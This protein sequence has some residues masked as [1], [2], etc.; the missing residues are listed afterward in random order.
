MCLPTRWR[1]ARSPEF[2]GDDRGNEQATDATDATNQTHG[3]ATNYATNATKRFQFAG[4]ASLALP[5]GD[6]STRTSRNTRD[7]QTLSGRHELDFADAIR[8]SLTRL[9]LN[10][11]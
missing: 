10:R 8:T 2:D 11:S 4:R 9:K 7:T 3:N 5:R 1:A 6:L